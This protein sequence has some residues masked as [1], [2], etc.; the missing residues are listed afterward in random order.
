MR[1]SAVDPDRY[2]PLQFTPNLRFT[3]AAGLGGRVPFLPSRRF[4]SPVNLMMCALTLLVHRGQTATEGTVSP[5]Y[6]LFPDPGGQAERPW[7][8]FNST[9]LASHLRFSELTLPGREGGPAWNSR[10]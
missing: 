7:M 6:R 1:L 10:V 4:C 8:R 2:L 3:I 9:C 5:A